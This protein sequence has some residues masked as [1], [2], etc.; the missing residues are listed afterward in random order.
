M[1]EIADMSTCMTICV[2]EIAKVYFA[3]SHDLNNV[4][5][6]KPVRY[7]ETIEIIE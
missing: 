4:I 2:L 3:L 7:I 5:I 6:A 1:L